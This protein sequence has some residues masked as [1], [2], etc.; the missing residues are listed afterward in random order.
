M[1]LLLMLLMVVHVWDDR[2]L[3]AE[4]ARVERVPTVQEVREYRRALIARRQAIQRQAE[5][6]PASP[7]RGIAIERPGDDDYEAG[8]WTG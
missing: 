5:P 3:P 2:T 1:L 7:R 4:P 6:P 8:Q